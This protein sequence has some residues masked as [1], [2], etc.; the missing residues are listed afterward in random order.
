MTLPFP[1]L[2]ALVAAVLARAPATLEVAI[3]HSL[4]RADAGGAVAMPR[5][6]LHE[7]SRRI[8]YPI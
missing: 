3:E 5:S 4:A 8:R 6:A 7:G 1:W 2:G